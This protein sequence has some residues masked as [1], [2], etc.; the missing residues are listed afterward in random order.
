M[1]V[2]CRIRYTCRRVP[3]KKWIFI[4]SN[5]ILSIWTHSVCQMCAMFLRDLIRFKKRKEICCCTFTSSIKYRIRRF[6]VTVMQRTE[7]M[8]RNVLK[9]MTHVQSCYFAHKTNYCL[10]TLLLPS[11]LWFVQRQRYFTSEASRK[12]LHM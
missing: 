2:V 4:L 9:T 5:F 8:K 6:R 10:L 12:L 3:V 11:L 7:K 1:I